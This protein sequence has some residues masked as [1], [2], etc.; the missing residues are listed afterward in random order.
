MQNR[1]KADLVYVV[2]LQQH[3][4][5]ETQEK[6]RRALHGEVGDDVILIGHRLPLPVLLFDILLQ[7]E[8]RL[9]RNVVLLEE[10]LEQTCRCYYIRIKCLSCLLN[11]HLFHFAYAGAN[12]F[13]PAEEQGSRTVCVRP[14]CEV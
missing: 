13:A 9:L 1:P 14:S 11:C 3:L 6:G 10:R 8:T 7:V 5:Q 12:R 2:G 4:P